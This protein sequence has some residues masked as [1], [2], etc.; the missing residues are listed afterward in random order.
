MVHERC[1]QKKQGAKHQT[2]IHV[3]SFPPPGETEP[4]LWG[5]YFPCLFFTEY[6]IL[7]LCHFLEAQSVRGFQLP[8]HRHRLTLFGVFFSRKKKATTA[9]RIKHGSHDGTSCHS[10][11]SHRQ[12]LWDKHCRGIAVTSAPDHRMGI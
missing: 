1:Q 5:V 10:Q 4:A 12:L 11:D 3:K 7:K 8:R 9:A 6:N 2:Q